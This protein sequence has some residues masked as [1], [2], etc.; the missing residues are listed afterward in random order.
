MTNELMIFVAMVGVA[1]FL[2]SQSVAVQAFGDNSKVRKRL[3]QRL[4]EI[5]STDDDD[6][7]SSLL[8]EKIS[9]AAVAV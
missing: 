5:E 6:S 8:R 1:V 4:K 9:A 2:L 3:Q 7:Y